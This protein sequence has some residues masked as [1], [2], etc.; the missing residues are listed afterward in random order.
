MFAVISNHIN[1]LESSPTQ[2]DTSTPPET[3]TVVPSNRRDPPL[4]GGNSTKIG[5]VWTLKHE[6]ISP[7][8]YELLMKIEIKGNTALY[9]KNFY[10]HINMC[11]NA[12]TR[13]REDLLLVTSPSKRH[14]NFSEYFIPDRDHP[15]YSWNV[16]IYTSLGNSLLVAMTTD[17]CLK[18]SMAPQS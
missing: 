6:I 7:K 1:T 17:T 16:Q 15:S 13:L 9:F 3:T 18:S 11:L 4:E 14:F 5:G 2:K 12:A 8:L 10:N